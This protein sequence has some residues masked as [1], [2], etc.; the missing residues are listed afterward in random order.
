[1]DKYICV[2]CGYVY[3]PAENDNVPFEELPV[4]WICPVCAV[5]KDR[6]V[7]QQ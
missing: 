1:M 7:K 3:D 4:D 2:V 5:G 6:F